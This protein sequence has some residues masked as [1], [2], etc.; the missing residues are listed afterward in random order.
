MQE[1]PRG[2]RSPGN[3]VL[4]PKPETRYLLAKGLKCNLTAFLLVVHSTCS[5]D[6]RKQWARGEFTCRKNDGYRWEVHTIQWSRMFWTNQKTR[7]SKPLLLKH[8]TSVYVLVGAKSWHLY[9]SNLKGCPEFYYTQGLVYYNH[10]KSSVLNYQQPQ[11]ERVSDMKLRYI[12]IESDQFASSV[13]LET[14]SKNTLSDVPMCC[15]MTGLKT[16]SYQPSM[17]SVSLRSRLPGP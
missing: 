8:S 2:F 17:F 13:E 11:A 10:G 3:G 7:Y 1:T 14:H 16:K 9:V 5:K 15:T 4:M 12:P 6:I